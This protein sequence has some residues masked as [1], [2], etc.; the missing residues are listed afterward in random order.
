MYD[1]SHPSIAWRERRGI[2]GAIEGDMD[3]DVDPGPAWCN[4]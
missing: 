1:L 3:I 2:G 4:A